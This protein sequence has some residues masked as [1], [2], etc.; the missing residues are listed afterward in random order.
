MIDGAVLRVVPVTSEIDAELFVALPAVLHCDEPDFVGADADDVAAIFRHGPALATLDIAR[1]LAWRGGVAVG[2][3]AA[4]TRGGGE[5]T[6]GFFASVDDTAVARA[7]L[8]A[9]CAWAR[10]RGATTVEGPLNIGERDRYRGVLERAD[11]PVLF[12]ENENPPSYPAL[13]VGAGAVRAYGVHT[14][15]LDPGDPAEVMAR[16]LR[17]AAHAS[18]AVSL[19]PYDPRS[20]DRFMDVLAEVYGAAFPRTG[21]TP[22]LT[23]VQ[24]EGVVASMVPIAIPE[25]LWC[26]RVEGRPAGFCVTLRDLNEAALAARAGV[27]YLASR[28]K[29]MAFAVHPDFQ[30]LGVAATMG[31]Q[32]HDVLA[33]GPHLRHLYL[34]GISAYGAGMR[35]FVEQV[36]KARLSHVHGVYRRACT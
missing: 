13:L 20:P 8:D 4:A 9:A 34:A 16:R 11:G 3:I 33:R 17:L 36:L 30:R 26:A 2:R 18:G 14:Y 22:A 1:W 27:P 24:L 10:A 29:G 31:L 25:L 5:A 15:H 23:R 35:G 32:V 19:E 7:L 28:A 12:Q 6:F 21:S